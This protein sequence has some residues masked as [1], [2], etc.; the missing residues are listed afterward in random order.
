[1][2]FNIKGDFIMEIL[3]LSIGVLFIQVSCAMDLISI[4]KLANRIKKHDDE[5]SK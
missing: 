5:L 2:K 1:M 4:F 3:F